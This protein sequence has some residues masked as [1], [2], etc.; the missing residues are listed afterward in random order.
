MRI[1]MW[2]PQRHVQLRRI[3]ESDVGYAVARTAKLF[4]KSGDLKGIFVAVHARSTRYA[5]VCRYI[6]F[7]ARL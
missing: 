7:L 6:V 3:I 4:V 5:Q 2:A 1:A